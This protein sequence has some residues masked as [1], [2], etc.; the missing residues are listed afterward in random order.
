D[1]VE[2]LAP[3]PDFKIQLTS[4]APV[5][6]TERVPL[7]TVLRNLIGNALKHHHQTDGNITIALDKRD[8]WWEFAVSDDGPGIDPQFYE[9]IFELFQT[10]QPRDKVEGSGMGLA[11]V[12]RIVET[13]GGKV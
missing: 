8:G 3:P 13:R 1:I 4:S 9:R 12:R 10:L 2:T 7:E 11:I 5:I 6:R